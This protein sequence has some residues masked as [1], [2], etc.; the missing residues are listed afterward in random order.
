ML[1][2][3]SQQTRGCT[4]SEE[5]AQCE[6]WGVYT[7]RRKRAAR[8]REKRERSGIHDCKLALFIFTATFCSLD[9]HVFRSFF[10]S[11]RRF[12]LVWCQHRFSLAYTVSLRR[13]SSIGYT[14]HCIAPRTAHTRCAHAAAPGEQGRAHGQRAQLSGAAVF[15]SRHR[16]ARPASISGD[17][18]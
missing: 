12:R 17:L 14:D 16:R 13:F 11:S 2:A 6:Q 7:D 10:L 9:S 3:R 5:K 8:Q 1:T 18:S 4:A 15:P